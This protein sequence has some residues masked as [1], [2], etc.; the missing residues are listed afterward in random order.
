MGDQV[1]VVVVPAGATDITDAN[2]YYINQ[3][4]NSGAATMLTGMGTKALEADTDYEIW[5]GGSN[6]TIKKGAF[7]TKVEDPEPTYTLGDVD[8]VTGININDATTVT[9]YVAGSYTLEGDLLLAADVDGVKGVNINDAT[10]I[11]KYVA[12]SVTE[13]TPAPA[14]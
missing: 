5:V 6:G 9:K 8:G 10:T 11:T 12:G 7:T 4:A 14:N 3:D 13:F 1:T 2:I